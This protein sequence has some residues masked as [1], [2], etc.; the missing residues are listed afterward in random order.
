MR[1]V[2]EYGIGVGECEGEVRGCW[3]IRSTLVLNVQRRLDRGWIRPS[4]SRPSKSEIAQGQVIVS[5]SG[6]DA[7]PLQAA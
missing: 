3:R 1:S 7:G 4:G 2:A 6:L 5:G